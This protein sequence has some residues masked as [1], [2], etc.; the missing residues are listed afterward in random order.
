MN[1]GRLRRTAVLM[2][3]IAVLATAA[4]ASAGMGDGHTGSYG[5]HWL[6]DS[7]E[8]PAVTCVYGDD[9]LLDKIR[10]RPPVIQA[11][12]G[13]E[14][15]GWRFR[16][17]RTDDDSTAYQSPIQTATATKEHPAHLTS[18]SRAISVLDAT[19]YLVKFT[20]FWY[21]P[22]SSAVAGK[23]PH[24]PLWYLRAYDAPFVSNECTTGLNSSAS[25]SVVP[26]VAV[27]SGHFGPHWLRDGPEFPVV[28]CT[29]DSSGRLTKV[30]IR[31]P[32]V[33][34]YPRAGDGRQKVGSSAAIYVSDQP[35]SGYALLA[36]GD[37][38]LATA[39]EGHA[40]HFS[41]VT[42]RAPKGIDFYV[43]VH[44][45]L[46]WYWP[47]L[48][49]QDGHAPHDGF[50]YLHRVPGDDFIRNNYCFHG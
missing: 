25:S 27:D 32:I 14:T 33:Q 50:Y 18:M 47:N 13:T 8:F 34:A 36:Q 15:V 10:V 49:T 19:S 5:L 30:F 37:I 46:Y 43:R 39:T 3:T 16:I 6:R 21:E 2:A 23:A 29:Y 17:I 7:E 26:A 38:E 11:H 20:L 4:T 44:F 42:F 9:A 28:R 24:D 41:P 22:G 35:D 48:A 1:R 45:D 31:P 12:S 40:A